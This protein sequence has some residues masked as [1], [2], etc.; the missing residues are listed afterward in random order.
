MNQ[1]RRF[2]EICVYEDLLCAWCYIASS[3]LA[4]LRREFGDAV[5][6]KRRPYPLR[7]AE[8]VA[9]AKEL[10]RWIRD[11]DVARSE[12]EGARL[13]PDLWTSGDPPASNIAPLLAVEAAGLQGAAARSV[14]MDAMRRAALEQG[15]NIARADVA[16]E[17]ASAVG[18]NMNQFSAAYHSPQTRRFILEEHRGAVAR[19][20][21]GVPTLV[22]ERRWMI[23]GLR[24]PSEYRRHIRS[25][26]T[27]LGLSTDGSPERMLH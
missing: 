22:I 18:L 1:R 3:R 8:R 9:S 16:L 26:M 10:A 7:I 23:S 4:I 27:K 25:C 17:L 5:R 15:I 13:S 21:D 20:I 24:D 12:P 6:W 11:V 19:G 14:Y 2:V